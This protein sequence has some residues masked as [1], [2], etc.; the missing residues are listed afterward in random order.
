M[1]DNVDGGVGGKERARTVVLLGAGASKDAGLPLT[2][3]LAA[4]ILDKANAT[5]DG[6]S[7]L[8]KPDWVRAINAVYAGMIGYEGARGGNPRSAVNIETLIS[9]I[10]LLGKRDT[11]EV[12]P[13]VASWAPSLSDFGSSNLP[14][15]SGKAI[16]DAVGNALGS[17][18][19]FGDRDI[20]EAVA[21][22]ARAALRPD[23]VDPLARA[24]EFIL[25]TLVELLGA[26]DDVSYFAPLL[27][28]VRK[29]EGGLDVITLNYDLTV[30]TAAEEEGIPVNR[31]VESWHPG[32]FLN[33]PP[34]DGMLNLMKLH[35]SLDWGMSPS[36]YET[37]TNL[38]PVGIRIITPEPLSP[39]WHRRQP[40]LPWI[41]VGDR[42]KLATDGPTLVLNF[43]ARS[44]L[45][46]ADH[47][48]I[49]GY[50]FS[51]AHI[52]A[53]IRDWL[54]GSE[55][56]TISILDPHWPR[57]HYY[58]ARDDFRSA[59]MAEHGR[60][61]DGRLQKIIPRVQPVEG[62]TAERLHDVLKPP[63]PDPDPIVTVA[64]SRE[65]S[66][67]RFD[68]TWLGADLFDV[69]VTAM[70]SNEAESNFSYPDD[71]PL[72]ESLP[73]PTDTAFRNRS[74]FRRLREQWKSRTLLT[75]YASAGTV[76][77]LELEIRGSSIAGAQGWRGKVGEGP[78]I[79]P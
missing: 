55:N 25:G 75:L 50:S 16:L 37:R 47:L 60:R 43:A 31:G 69:D 17:R 68:V 59:L 73:I 41:V 19:G 74:G 78:T 2:S 26:H 30:E 63:I 32:E 28:L 42:E 7:A 8:I 40:E 58:Q 6:H 45:L 39:A 77:P 13:F 65:E 33:F 38:S 20:T 18:V 35:G 10:R 46:R 67:V 56:R 72:F 27:E 29:Q 53:M 12:A 52:N 36:K 70:P 64:V 21:N 71:I 61:S 66:A 34:I 51:D 22:I 23:L 5:G 11:H 24:E 15:Q 4:K 3:E 57:V 79:V 49:A 76:L 62:G 54:G 9:A 1:E 44:A 48:A 14:T